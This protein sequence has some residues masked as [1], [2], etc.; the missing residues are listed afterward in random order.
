VADEPNVATRIDAGTIFR[1]ARARPGRRAGLPWTPTAWAR[2]LVG[3]DEP[4]PTWQRGD[5]IY[6]D[7]PDGQCVRCRIVNVL[8]DGTI[9]VVPEHPVTI[10]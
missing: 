9:Q 4:E 6:V 3:V 7:L 1:F 8:E 2:M 5:T 10:A